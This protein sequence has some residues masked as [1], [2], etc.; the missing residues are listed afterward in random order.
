MLFQDRHPD[1]A[2][3]AKLV[4]DACYLWLKKI[5]SIWDGVIGFAP[6]N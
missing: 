2:K 4:A 1:H 3:G 6:L 5:N